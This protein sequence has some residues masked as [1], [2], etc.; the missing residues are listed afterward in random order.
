MRVP[1][2]NELYS[3]RCVRWTQLD[4]H[5]SNLKSKYG[6]WLISTSS[7]G[8]IELFNWTNQGWPPNL[9]GIEFI[10]RCVDLPIKS[11]TTLELQIKLG[12][13]GSTCT[14]EATACDSQR[15]VTLENPPALGFVS[16]DWVFFHGINHH[17]RMFLFQVSFKIAISTVPFVA[18]LRDDYI[19]INHQSTRIAAPKSRSWCM[20]AMQTTWIWDVHTYIRK[21][22]SWI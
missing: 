20:K 18:K 21:T 2:A 15:V 10:C 17:L 12:I 19:H 22:N 9:L 4:L 16:D 6:L 8:P 13:L 7:G 5:V 14:L 1:V 3:L 11:G